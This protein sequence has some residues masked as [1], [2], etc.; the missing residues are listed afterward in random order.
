MLFKAIIMP[1]D[2]HV[3]RN[4]KYIFI[5][6]CIEV[7]LLTTSHLEVELEYVNPHVGHHFLVDISFIT[8][9]ICMQLEI[10]SL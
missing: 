6:Q 5:M 7:P 10:S 2:T 8:Y 1:T 3:E 9:N 4:R